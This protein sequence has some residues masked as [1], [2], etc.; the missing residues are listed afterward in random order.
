MK[1]I[2]ILMAL[3]ISFSLTNVEAL[4]LDCSKT[5]VKGNKGN[6]VLALQKTL[7]EI[8]NCNLD[9]DG[10]FGNKTLS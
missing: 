6:N 7:N 1:K 3:I 4:E 2:L 8:M 10:I 5:L 9:N